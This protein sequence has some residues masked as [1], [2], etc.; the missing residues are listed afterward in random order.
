MHVLVLKL[1]TSNSNYRHLKL[2]Y[3]NTHVCSLVCF[4]QSPFPTHIHS[5]MYIS[6]V[7]GTGK[8]ATINEIARSLRE[9]A[10]EGQVPSF[11]FVELNGLRLTEPH[12]AYVTILKVL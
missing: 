9:A 12:Q 7:P 2:S 3:E 6:G 5:C 4:N 10:S 8:T 1:V 11:N